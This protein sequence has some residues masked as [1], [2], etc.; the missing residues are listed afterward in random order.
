[1][2]GLNDSQRRALAVTLHIVEQRLLEIERL[3]DDPPSGRMQRVQHDLSASRIVE[4]RCHAAEARA[5]I[6]SIA[7]CFDLEPARLSI[8]RQLAAVLSI[9]WANLE[10]ARPAGLSRYGPVYPA[11][12]EALDEPLAAL[13]ELM[14]RMAHI[15]TDP[16]PYDH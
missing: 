4:L 15:S 7:D 1:M 14:L 6:E 12:A 10:D 16:G 3:L 11:V 2:M 5:R 8:R 9:S 13:S